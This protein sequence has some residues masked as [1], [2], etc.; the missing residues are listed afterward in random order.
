MEIKTRSV[1]P[2]CMKEGKGDF[3]DARVYEDKGKVWIEHICKVHGK[4]TEVY[5]SDAEMFKRAYKFFSNGRGVSNPAIQS[6]NCP[7]DCGLCPLHRSGTLLA[8]L[9]VTNRCNLNCWYCFAHAGAVGYIFEPSFDEIIKMLKVLRDQKPVPCPAV[10]LSGGE[11]TIRADI[12]DIV[13]EAAKMG[14]KQ[15]QIATNGIRIAKEKGFAKALRDAGLDTIY[16]K[17]NGM[18]PQTNIEN[19]KYKDDILRECREAHLGIVLVPTIIGGF[20]TDQIGPII[21][22]AVENVDIIRAVNFQPISF[23]G[24]IDKISDE[25]RAKE[26]FTIPDLIHAAEKQTKFLKADDWY[27][28]PSV[29]PVSKIVEAFKGRPQVQFSAHP[30]CGMATYVF[31]EDGKPIPITRFLKVDEF[32][33]YLNNLKVPKNKLEKAALAAKIF[34]DVNKFLDKKS[35]PKSFN[36]ADLLVGVLIK[37]QR[38]TLAKIHWNSLLISSMHFQDAWNLDF[39]RLSRCVIHYAVPDGRLIPFCAYNTFPEYRRS[40][41]KKFSM[42]VKEWKAAHPGK[43]ITDVA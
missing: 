33:E 14:F 40:V 30:A 9:D 41:E 11:P 4:I 12:V 36:L 24:R 2:E 31:V 6:E 20:N 8:N 23:V 28:V 35:K 19:L 15:V 27:P 13:R 10:Q 18:T 16:M 1:C 32:L 29:M 37:G 43:E 34:A 25:Q 3:V 21:N 22:W 7:H 5:W 42:S 26:R 39:E 38:E 17:W